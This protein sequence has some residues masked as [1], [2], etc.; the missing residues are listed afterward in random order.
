MGGTG[1]F[2]SQA[3]VLRQNLYEAALPFPLNRTKPFLGA[4]AHSV[5]GSENSAWH[6]IASC[7][8]REGLP[9]NVSI[10]LSLGGAVYLGIVCAS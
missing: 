8:L 3:F 9:Q 5:C 1:V 6:G 7:S 10:R 2:S 4:Q